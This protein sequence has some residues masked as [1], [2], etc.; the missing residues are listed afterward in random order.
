MAIRQL[1][2]L[3]VAAVG[4]AACARPPAVVSTP[5]AVVVRARLDTARVRPYAVTE[6]RAF[7]AAVRRGT[8]TRTGSPG[9]AY[10]QQR[11]R[12]QLTAELDPAN[13][14]LT[15]RGAVR[16]FNRSPDTLPALFVHLHQ[17]LFQPGAARTEETPT[18]TGMEIK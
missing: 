5:P 16:Y 9:P 17:N 15:G 7:A 12:Y 2:L 3:V 6:T 11:T 10:W 4:I 14:R 13:N 1:H 8:R 18:T